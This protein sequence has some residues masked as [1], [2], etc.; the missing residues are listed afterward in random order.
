MDG[1]RYF[2]YIVVGCGG[3]GSGTLYWLS[4]KAGIDVLGLEQ[5][6]LGHH[7]GGSQDHSR[8]IRLAYHDNRYTKLTPDT[9]KAWEAVEKEAG[10]QLVYN[11]GGVQFTRKDEM[12]HVIDAYAKAMAENNISFERL[13]GSQL[14]A[15]FPQFEIDDTYDTIYQPIAGLVDAALANSVHVQLARANGASILEHCPV[16]KIEKLPNGRVLVHT[17]KGVFQCRRLIVTAGAWINHVLGSIG[18][19]IP[20][21]VTQEQVTYFA[22]PNVKDFTK[23]KYPIWIYHSP[24]Y[25]FY[26]MPMHGNSGSKIGIDAGGPVVSVDTRNYEPDKTREQAFASLLGKILSE[27][28]I[29]G[30][31]KYDISKFNIDREAITNPDW[32]PTLYMGTGGKVPT[33]KSSTSKL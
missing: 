18:V 25:D 27:M 9:Y 15:K 7:N 30:K 4:K 29:D 11:T 26:G 10:L 8:I 28:A 17:P 20:V 6:E 22:T 1:R 14:R 21:Y 12:T 3:V 2:E 33:K 19:H 31:T 13:K 23:A 24:K 32:T 5:F 16:Q